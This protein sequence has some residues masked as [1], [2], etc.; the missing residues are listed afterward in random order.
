MLFEYYKLSCFLSGLKNEIRLIVKMF[1]PTDLL[2]AYGL[3]KIQEEKVSLCKKLPYKPSPY[4]TIN[5][6]HEPAYLESSHSPHAT[7]NH[8][9][10]LKAIVSI[11]KVSQQDMKERWAKGLCYSCYS[12]WAP[13]HKFSHPRLYLIEEIHENYELTEIDTGKDEGQ[14]SNPPISVSGKTLEIS[15]C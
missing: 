1:N 2:T 13:G 4:L 10:H 15:L 14:M 6:T 9:N 12:K 3:A 8:N 7:D 11:Q 5:Q